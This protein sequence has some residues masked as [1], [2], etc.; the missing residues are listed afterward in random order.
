MS[1]QPRRRPC[2]RIILGLDI[3]DST[4]RMDPARGY[5]RTA[6]Y[7]SLEEALSK[8]GIT[9]AH[10]ELLDRGDGVMALIRSDD[11]IPKT[12][13][14]DTVVPALGALLTAHNAD[15]PNNAYR[16]RVVVS[17]GEV[18][19]DDRGWYGEA[20]DAAFRLLESKEAKTML[21]GTDAPLVLVVSE[22]IYNSVVRQGYDDIDATGWVRL[23]GR[24][25]SGASHT[26]WARPVHSPPLRQLAGAQIRSMAAYRR[27][28]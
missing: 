14:L 13:L 25:V 28:A 9:E 2:H 12:A 27:Q 5:L 10:R 17:A 3:E 18:T 16:L 19:Y 1:H 15:H 23:R 21:R 11:A 8:A 4:R 24:R 6:M 7:T 26:G 22:E 20:L